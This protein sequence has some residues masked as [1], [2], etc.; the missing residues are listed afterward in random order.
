MGQETISGKEA[1]TVHDLASLSTQDYKE[2][3]PKDADE[4]GWQGR[5]W[6]SFVVDVD[7]S[8][9][10]VR[11]ERKVHP[12]L[13]KEAVR[14]VSSMPKWKPGTQDGKPVRVRFSTNVTFK[15][16]P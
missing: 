8:V 16:A 3:Y 4:Q 1:A 13:D 11:V 5:V 6:V 2:E 14:V 12:S 9:T 15:Q 10:D 7:G